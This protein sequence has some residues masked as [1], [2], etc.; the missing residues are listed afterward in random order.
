MAIVKRPP[1]SF[2][3][4]G[5]MSSRHS[6]P[7]IPPAPRG[8][9]LGEVIGVKDRLLL[10]FGVPVMLLR[11]SAGEVLAISEPRVDF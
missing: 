8:T 10:R 3:G 5:R 7:R 4:Q 1:D 6:L 11:G 2:Y 9:R